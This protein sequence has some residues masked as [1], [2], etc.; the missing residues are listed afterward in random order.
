MGYEFEKMENLD[1]TVPVNGRRCLW[2]ELRCHYTFVIPAVSSKG[3]LQGPIWIKQSLLFLFEGS[4]GEI[5]ETKQEQ[6]SG[7]MRKVKRG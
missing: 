5:W 1:K 6:S 3:L 4:S 7:L 2:W